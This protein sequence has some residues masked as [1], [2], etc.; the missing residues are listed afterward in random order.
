MPCKSEKKLIREATKI[1]VRLHFS[2]AT[3]NM[4]SRLDLT[5]PKKK[6]DHLMAEIR[7]SLSKKFLNTKLKNISHVLI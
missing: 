6:S 5:R 3:K 7:I 4:A 1:L 2:E